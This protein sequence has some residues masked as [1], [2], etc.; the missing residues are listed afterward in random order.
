MKELRNISFF[1]QQKLVD[2]PNHVKFSPH[3]L[4]IFEASD[5][6]TLVYVVSHGSVDVMG[7]RESIV[8]FEFDSA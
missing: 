2:V 5:G 7:E 4:D 1:P 8:K 3:G 6:R